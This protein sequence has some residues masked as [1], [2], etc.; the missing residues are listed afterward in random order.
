MR[1]SKPW[2]RSFP[3]RYASL[4]WRP[5][6]PLASRGPAA[7]HLHR[8]SAVF[9]EKPGAIGE[10]LFR[11]FLVIGGA[12]P[13][14]VVRRPPGVPHRQAMTRDHCFLPRTGLARFFLA[15]AGSG[16]KNPEGVG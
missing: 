5:G 10:G 8:K 7:A 13:R 4:P 12:A 6:T 2:K 3:G 11:P 14:V 16:E 9:L 15:G 1:C